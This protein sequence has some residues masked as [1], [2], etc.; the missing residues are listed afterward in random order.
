MK[1]CRPKEN[2]CLPNQFVSVRSSRNV[3][4]LDGGSLIAFMAYRIA[5]GS[6]I[7]LGG[8]PLH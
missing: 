3:Y 1:I 6:R 5:N 7:Y 8:V 4:L 2:F